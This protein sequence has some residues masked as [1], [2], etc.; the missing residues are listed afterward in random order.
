MKRLRIAREKRRGLLDER[1]ELID[2]KRGT[3][4]ATHSTNREINCREV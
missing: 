4:G 1:R 3:V 2:Q